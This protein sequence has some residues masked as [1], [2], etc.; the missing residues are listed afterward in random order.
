LINL[1]ADGEVLKAL[2]DDDAF[3]ETLMAK[4]TVCRATPHF[5]NIDQL[6]GAALLVEPQGAKCE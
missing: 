4:I 6:T 2:A 3:I 1:S 5:M